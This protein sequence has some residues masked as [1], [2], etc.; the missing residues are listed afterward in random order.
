[1][2]RDSR[3]HAAGDPADSTDSAKNL[4]KL[5]NFCARIE[6]FSRQIFMARIALEDRSAAAP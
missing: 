6:Q 1:M 2:L 4:I 5:K 3:A